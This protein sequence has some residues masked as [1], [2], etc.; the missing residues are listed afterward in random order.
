MSIDG[1][2]YLPGEGWHAELGADSHILASS[3]PKDHIFPSDSS[4]NQ[5]LAA[6]TQNISTNTACPG[7]AEKH[8]GLGYIHW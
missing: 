8:S 7:H 2:L 1:Y 6:N 3:N 4:S 5:I